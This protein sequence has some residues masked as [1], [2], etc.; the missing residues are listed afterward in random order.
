MRSF[1]Q[2]LHEFLTEF[3]LTQLGLQLCIRANVVASCA[4]FTEGGRHEERRKAHICFASPDFSDPSNWQGQGREHLVSERML[5]RDFKVLNLRNIPLVKDDKAKLAK[6]TNIWRHKKVEELTKPR[7]CSSSPLLR[8]QHME[9]SCC[10]EHDNERNS[11]WRALPLSNSIALSALM[12]FYLISTGRRPLYWRLLRTA[13]PA[14]HLFLAPGVFCPDFSLPGWV[15]KARL[16]RIS[17]TMGCRAVAG[18]GARKILVST[19]EGPST[20]RRIQFLSL[21]TSEKRHHTMDVIT[22]SDYF[23]YS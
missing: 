10:K 23:R 4:L 18:V 3:L 1:A 11:F 8:A 21:S 6:C 13:L 16:F 12:A 7:L 5:A 19:Q 20:H 15:E 22:T 2:I 17:M 14:S 9:G